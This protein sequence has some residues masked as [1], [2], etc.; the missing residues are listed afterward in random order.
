MSVSVIWMYFVQ[1]AMT[2]N[3]Q[4][5]EQLTPLNKRLDFH[6]RGRA[7]FV[8]MS[9]WVSVASNSQEAH[10]LATLGEL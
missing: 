3:S 4:K 8:T 5:L 10:L 9:H 7:G 2:L 6:C 1:L